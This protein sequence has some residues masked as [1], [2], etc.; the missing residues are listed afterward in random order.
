MHFDIQFSLRIEIALSDSHSIFVYNKK[1]PDLIY[2]KKILPMPNT[3]AG[4]LTSQ[5]SLFVKL[6][7]KHICRK[8]S[9]AAT[10]KSKAGTRKRLLSIGAQLLF[11][12]LKV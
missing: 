8:H 10:D 4:I 6:K 3:D 9:S 2:M 12:P 11:L 7:K 5:K 1:Y